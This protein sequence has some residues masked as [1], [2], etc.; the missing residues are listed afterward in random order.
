MQRAGEGDD[1][2]RYVWYNVNKLEEILSMNTV[3]RVG[4]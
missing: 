1:V 2:K 4:I 3:Y